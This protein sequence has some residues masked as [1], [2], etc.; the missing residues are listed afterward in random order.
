MNAFNLV[1]CKNKII[2][3]QLTLRQ[4]EKISFIYH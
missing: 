4:L 3:R 2:G 1:I